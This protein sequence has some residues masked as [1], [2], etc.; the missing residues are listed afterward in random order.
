MHQL[1]LMQHLVVQ[2]VVLL[3]Y[4]TDQMVSVGQELLDKVLQVELALG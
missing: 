1:G 3:G 2:V 4:M